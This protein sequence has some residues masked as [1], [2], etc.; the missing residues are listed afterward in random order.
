MKMIKPIVNLSKIS[1]NFD[2]FVFGYNGVIHNG[3][4]INPSAAECLEHLASLNKKIII[5][6]NSGLRVA[7]IAQQLSS[8]HIPLKIFSNII[9]AGEVLHYKLKFP[10]GDYQAIGQ[11]YYQ[12]GDKEYSGIMSSLPLERVN[13][14]EKAHFLFMAKAKSENDLL[15]NYR[16]DIEQ[17]VSYGLP[18]VCA[19]NDT[20]CFYNG[21]L[22]LAPGAIAEAYAVLGGRVITVGKPDVKM[23]QYALEGIGETGKIAIIGDNVSTDIKMASIAQ[24]SSILISKGRHINYLGEGYIPD[25]TK[26]RELS[27]SFDVEPEGV[28]SELRW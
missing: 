18:F 9:S 14:I 5:I 16:V 27:N 26:T 24:I 12:I 20:S 17:A 10:S 7:E 21:K 25:V 1:D 4:N 13:S 28:I 22:T 8:S 11:C 19:G 23:L 2:T 15:D 6:S 3:L